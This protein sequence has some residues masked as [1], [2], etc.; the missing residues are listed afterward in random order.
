MEETTKNPARTSAG[1]FLH[2]LARDRSGNTFAIVAAA[3]AP[4]LALVGGGIDMGRSYLSESR[5]QQACDAGVLAARKKLGAV[6][7]DGGVIPDDVADAG[8]RFFNLNFRN[9][10]YGSES[11]TF[12]M[13][14]DDDFSISGAA[15]VIVP[16]TIMRL[17][18]NDQV[19][20]KV[21]CQ[22][23]LNFSNTDIMM[24]LD[25]TA[26]MSETN[27]GDTEPRI[28]VLRKTA[29]SFFDSVMNAKSD[30][31]RV[32]WGFVPYTTNVNVGLL[33]NS[34]WMVDRWTYQTRVPI[35]TG[36]TQT[37]SLY[38]VNIELVS[39]TWEHITPYTS[40][41]CPDDTFTSVASP[42]TT[43]S[44]SPHQFWYTQVENG[45][46][47]N[48]N[49][50]DGKWLVSGVRFINFTQ[51]LT[52]TW[53]EDQVQKIYEFEY[54]PFEYDVSASNGATGSDPTVTATIPIRTWTPLSG[55]DGYVNLS[56]YGCIE[57][58]S[59]YEI[60]DYANV[61]FNRALDLNIDLVPDPNNPDTQWRP[62]MAGMSF[63]R[64]IHWSGNSGSYKLTPTRTGFQFY[65]P[66]WNNAYHCP[67]PARKLDEISGVFFSN[68]LDSLQLGGETYHDIGMIWGGRLL[69][70]SGLFAADNAPVDGK[71]TS[72]HLIFL[73]DGQTLA[74]EKNYNSYGVEP[75]DRRRWNPDAP[76]G[77]LT[78]TQV[79]EKRFAVACDQ[80]KKKNITVWVIGFGTTMNNLFKQCAG[81]GH[82]FQADDSTQL[83][84]AFQS[85]SRSMG[86]L[87]LTK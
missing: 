31:T 34:D 58:R 11:R 82:W 60:D 8:N 16:T 19:P 23:R 53:A 17:F 68:Y 32:R 5:L 74:L 29:R 21:D 84:A 79:V 87:R 14:M 44:T 56:Y 47:Y 36:N 57:E 59:T 37:V 7:P 6:K 52:F 81:P 70:G 78:Q 28:D 4:M 35:D 1:H 69:S 49:A 30:G 86:D 20:V 63:I 62:Q 25:T 27:A 22:A 54:G 50:N 18:G 42:N 83:E 40:D 76:L 15:S 33:L 38:S 85:I 43:V 64:D 61:D 72:R 2:H 45:D 39:G 67:T 12:T 55:N 65:N 75:L 66:S 10:A 13:T 41:T 9:G 77:G 48:C 26:S 51:K 71:P 46:D 80:V 24:V 3:I 73:T